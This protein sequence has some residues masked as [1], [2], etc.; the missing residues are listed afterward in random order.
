[1]TN[2]LEESASIL[3]EEKEDTNNREIEKLYSAIKQLNKIDR[4]IIL[5]YLEE[6]TYKEIAT[7][8]EVD[9]SNM[10]AISL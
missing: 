4:A 3:L 9:V 8:L 5:L 7:I 10:V 2:P 6:K 1:M